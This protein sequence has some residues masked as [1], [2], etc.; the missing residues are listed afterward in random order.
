[1]VKALKVR[2]YPTKAQEELLQ[3]T[4]GCTRYVYNHFL[5]KRISVY[6]ES[7]ETLTN[8]MCSK[9]LTQLKKELVWLKEV[10]K[11]S[12]Q[13]ALRDLDNAYNRFFNGSSKFPK[14]K[15]KKRITENHIEL[16]LQITV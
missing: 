12:L 6:K 11:W 1:M 7:K 10:D 15:S 8:N 9:E 16:L 5:D 3:K 13:N 4:F 2:V 14:F